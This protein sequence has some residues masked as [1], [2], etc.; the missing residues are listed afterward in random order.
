MLVYLPRLVYEIVEGVLGG[1]IGV[2][3]AVKTGLGSNVKQGW[4]GLAGRIGRCEEREHA[5]LERLRGAQRKGT[6]TETQ[7]ASVKSDR[8]PTSGVPEVAAD[9]T[10]RPAS[11]RTARRGHRGSVGENYHGLQL[12]GGLAILADCI[13][14]VCSLQGQRAT[15][16]KLGQEEQTSAFHV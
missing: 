10:V 6:P 1:P 8:A 12:D 11:G 13:H 9:R 15:S 3:L 5:S 16:Y 2:V 14:K 4:D 7:A